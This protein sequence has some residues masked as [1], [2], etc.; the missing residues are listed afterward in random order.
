METFDPT[1]PETA[2]RDV[3]RRML[4]VL[5][6]LDDPELRRRAL[7]RVLVAAPRLEAQELA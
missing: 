3:T 5:C 4:R 6:T 2:V 1:N 7:E